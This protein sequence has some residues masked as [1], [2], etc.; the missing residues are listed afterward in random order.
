M[1]LHVQYPLLQSTNDKTI[2]SLN[3]KDTT[4]STNYYKRCSYKLHYIMCH[5]C[6]HV[7]M[8]MY[9]YKLTLHNE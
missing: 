3:K 9:G 7:F 1:K 2:Q 8:Y 6:T 4:F 5:V